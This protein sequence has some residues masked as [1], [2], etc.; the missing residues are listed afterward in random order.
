MSFVITLQGNLIN[1]QHVM[2]PIVSNAMEQLMRYVLSVVMG[3]N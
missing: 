2:I 1:V 3:T